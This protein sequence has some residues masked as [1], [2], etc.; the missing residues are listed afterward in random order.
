MT[1]RVGGENRSDK[2]RASLEF[3]TAVGFN[4]FENDSGRIPNP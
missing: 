2:N 1:G 4:E 3:T